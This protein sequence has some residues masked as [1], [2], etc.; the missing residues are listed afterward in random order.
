MQTQ[1]LQRYAPNSLHLLFHPVD[2]GNPNYDFNAHL[3]KFANRR[4]DVD[5][6]APSSRQGL[7]LQTLYSGNITRIDLESTQ[8]IGGRQVT[9]G[10]P[11]QRDPL[12]R[13]LFVTFRPSEHFDRSALPGHT[14]K[15]GSVAFSFGI[16]ETE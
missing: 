4:V 9:V 14:V 8:L 2:T 6:V 5:S 1:F 15:G 12:H 11:A 10:H 16:A 7:R 13:L 3:E